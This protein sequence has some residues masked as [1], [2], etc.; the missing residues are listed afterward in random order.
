M[1]NESIS[2]NDDTLQFVRVYIICRWF[3][4]II[5]SIGII[6]NIFNLLVFFRK[7]FR[8]NSCT[9]Y[10]IAYSINNFMNLT[11]GLFIWSLTL[12]FNYDWEYKIL[13]YCKIRRYFTHIN[14]L[15]SSCLLTMAS[16]NRCARVR[17][18]KLTQN[19]HRYITLCEHRTTYI[20]VI[21]T[22]I[23]CLIVNVHIPIFFEIDEGE[24]YARKGVYRLLFDIFF[25]V[26]Y[27][28]CP[29]LLMIIC[30]IITVADIRGI[31]KLVNPSISRREYNMIILVLAH[32]LSNVI[33]ALPFTI[34]KFIY[35][36]FKEPVRSEKVQLANAVT[37]L[38]AFMNP[39]LSFF[40]YTLT[41]R[42]FRHEFVQVWKDLLMKTNLSCWRKKLNDDARPRCDTGKS[43]FSLQMVL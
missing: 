19:R 21:S 41:T 6:G 27:A 22:I 2:S 24:C 39:A 38:I 16:I 1:V 5:F 33:F 9:I 14:F 18:A 4:L 25:L 36:T 40:L 11:V 32:S 26:F 3:Y 34:N 7:K 8:S 30:N 10:F 37:L 43:I 13:P 29:P 20:I 12:G 35:Y 15:L 42:C 17:Q 23:F 31:K 28:L